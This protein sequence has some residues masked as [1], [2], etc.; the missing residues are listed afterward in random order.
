MHKELRMGRDGCV[1][2]P[3]P[4]WQSQLKHHLEIPFVSSHRMKL[5]QRKKLTLKVNINAAVW[6]MTS[7]RW[8]IALAAAQRGGVPTERAGGTAPT[9][10]VETPVMF[11]CISRCVSGELDTTS[12]GCRMLSK[13]V[14]NP[15]VN[16]MHEA[17][18]LRWSARTESGLLRVG[19]CGLSSL[20]R[21]L[22]S[23]IQIFSKWPCSLISVNLPNERQLPFLREETGDEL[24]MSSSRAAGSLCS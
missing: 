24:V 22:T 13:E 7:L 10:E 21:Q 14:K 18:S 12:W 19:A 3:A 1:S 23:K 17:A 4:C 6:E 11:K 5:T 20:Q 15:A 2:P 8:L 9:M 16:P